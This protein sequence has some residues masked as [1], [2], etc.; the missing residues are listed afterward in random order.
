MPPEVDLSSQGL[1]LRFLHTADL[2][3]GMKLR[4]VTGD[5]GARLRAQRF[6]TLRAL[7][8]LAHERSATA[9]VI[10][11]D[12]LDDNAVGPDTLQLAADALDSLAPLPVLILPGN[13][14]AA[15]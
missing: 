7:G 1:E 9:I 5:R 10:A 14:D 8:P 11:G 15:V 3:L 4:F 12:F 2:Q 6:D 13:H